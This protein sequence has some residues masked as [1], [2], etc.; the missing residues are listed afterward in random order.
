MRVSKQIMHSTSSSLQEI[1]E[2]NRKKL[3]ESLNYFT[4]IDCIDMIQDVLMHHLPTCSPFDPLS[5]LA[6]EGSR[7]QAMQFLSLCTVWCLKS[8]SHDA[9]WSLTLKV[10][11]RPATKWYTNIYNDPGWSTQLRL[12]GLYQA[13]GKS[14]RVAPGVNQ[15]G[16]LWHQHSPCMSL[17]I[18]CEHLP[19]KAPRQN[20]LALLALQSCF[21]FPTLP[22]TRWSKAKLRLG[23]ATTTSSTSHWWTCCNSIVEKIACKRP[24]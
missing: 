13:L 12:C 8:L 1:Q 21:R 17:W 5:R 16:M 2:E 24:R 9:Q 22:D 7:F 4:C 11:D 18:R 15:T 3:G 23:Q 20:R 19:T 14:E 10:L 6:V